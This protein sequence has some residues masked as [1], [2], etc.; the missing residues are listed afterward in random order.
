VQADA[1]RQWVHL[2][3]DVIIDW[4][5]LEPDSDIAAFLRDRAISVT[6]LSHDLTSRVDFGALE[7]LLHRPD[8]R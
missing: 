6:P 2:D 3:Y 8:E 5:T 7:R 1:E 4:E